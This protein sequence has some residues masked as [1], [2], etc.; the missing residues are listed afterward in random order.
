MSFGKSCLIKAFAVTLVFVGTQLHAEERNLKGLMQWEG[1]G[2]V[3]SIGVNQ[4][5]FQGAFNGILYIENEQGDLDGAFVNCPGTQHIDMETSDSFGAGYCEITVSSTDVVYA[6]WDCTGKVGDC[7]GTF[8]L[9]S[10]LGRFEG[11]K[12]GSDFRIRSIL[13]T[14]VKGL[15]SGSI[16]RAGKGIALLPNLKV[17]IPQNQ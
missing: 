1:E 4:M 15:G 13:G 16:V 7:K 9:I 14:L 11:I 6:E 8:R 2:S 10:G 12:G 3:H 17:T 5:L